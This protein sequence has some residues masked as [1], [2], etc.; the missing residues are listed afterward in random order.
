MQTIA[1]Q[2][3]IDGQYVACFDAADVAGIAAARS[4]GRAAGRLLGLNVCTV[5]SDPG[6]RADHQVVV[7]VAVTGG[8]SAEDAGR[9]AERGEML[10]SQMPAAS[11]RNS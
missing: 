8:M 6:K 10:I 5:E 9:L 4:A 7:V 11:E 3:E 1:R 2:L